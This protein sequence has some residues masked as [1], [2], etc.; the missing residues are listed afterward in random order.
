MIISGRI[1]IARIYEVPILPL[2]SMLESLNYQLFRKIFIGSAFFDEE[3][4]T[5][6]SVHYNQSSKL[7]PNWSGPQLNGW[8]ADLRLTQFLNKT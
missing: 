3:A 4:K 7:L 8:M 2:W 1:S 6:R 5:K